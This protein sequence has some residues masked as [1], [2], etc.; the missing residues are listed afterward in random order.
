MS[1]PC[2]P[3]ARSASIRSFERREPQFLEPHDLGQR[4]R[5]PGEVGERRSLPQRECCPQGLGRT[6][7]VAR[8]Q[9]RAAF[10]AEALKLERVD[11]IELDGEAVP[12]RHRLEGPLGQPLSD[13]RDVHLDGVPRRL[14]RVVAP[15]SV[16]QAVAGDNGVGLQKQDREQS[17][18]LLAP[19]RDR[20]PVLAC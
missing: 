19:E 15:E 18:P 13:L 11:G 5:L 4:E 3:S 1:W 12:R 2:R 16:D 14:G 9:R 17:P 6:G 8:G 10:L 7:W 20:G